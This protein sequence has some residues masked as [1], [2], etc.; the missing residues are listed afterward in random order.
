MPSCKN[1]AL[2]LLTLVQLALFLVIPAISRAAS[3]DNC[4]GTTASGGIF[5]GVD[6]SCLAGVE[7]LISNVTNLAFTAVGIVSV[8]F[9]IIGGIQ[10][11]VSTG[12]PS[13]TKKAKTTITYAILGLVLAISAAAIGNFVLSALN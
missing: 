9:I 6:T 2:R 12:N 4:Q 8:I 1:I 3:G 5:D 7:K 10:L 11:A 13:G